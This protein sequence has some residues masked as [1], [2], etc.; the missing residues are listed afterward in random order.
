MGLA[1]CGIPVSTATVMPFRFDMTGSVDRWKK[2]L[3]L[4]VFNRRFRDAERTQIA[5]RNQSEQFRDIGNCNGEG[6]FIYVIQL[7]A[8]PVRLPG[9]FDV[10]SW[11]SFSSIFILIY[12]RHPQLVIVCR[13]CSSCFNLGS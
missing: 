11:P 1:M 4:K 9:D 13:L 5:S 8:I 2:L 12:H 7:Y 10:L 3:F 6:D